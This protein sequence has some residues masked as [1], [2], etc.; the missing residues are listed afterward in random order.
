MLLSQREK[1]RERKGDGGEGRGRE[2][3]RVCRKS[4]QDAPYLPGTHGWISWGCLNVCVSV[5]V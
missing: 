1:E 5:C 4:M 2:R 3:E